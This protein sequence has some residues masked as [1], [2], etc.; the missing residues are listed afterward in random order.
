M[1]I[2]YDLKFVA[3]GMMGANAPIVVCV[4]F[5]FP[6]LGGMV[7]GY[8]QQGD[9]FESPGNISLYYKGRGRF[10]CRNAERLK[11]VGK[12]LSEV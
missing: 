10:W 5:L 12:K 6:A 8:S 4:V 9:L 7:F 3:S 1:C 11:C 2:W